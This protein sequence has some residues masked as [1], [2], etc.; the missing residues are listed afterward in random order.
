MQRRNLVE[1]QK[2]VTHDKR[3]PVKQQTRV[4]YQQLEC[5]HGLRYLSFLYRFKS[6]VANVFVFLKN[7]TYQ[8]AFFKV[9]ETFYRHNDI[10]DSLII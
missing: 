4:G 7:E 5:M 9:S 8:I 1:L 6:L 3:T 2:V 10:V